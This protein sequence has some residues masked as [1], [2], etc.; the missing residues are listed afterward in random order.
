VLTEMY[1]HAESLRKTT[2]VRTRQYGD[3]NIF[4]TWFLKDMGYTLPSTCCTGV[5]E[6]Q[7]K[8][9]VIGVA[10]IG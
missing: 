10:H 5:L 9:E 2:V 7:L 8:S 6:A 4:V 1:T 3:I